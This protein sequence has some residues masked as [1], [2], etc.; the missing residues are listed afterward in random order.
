MTEIDLAELGRDELVALILKQAAA[1]AAPQAE[2]EA[3]ERSGKRPAASF[4]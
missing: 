4:S 2:I 3:L 1:I